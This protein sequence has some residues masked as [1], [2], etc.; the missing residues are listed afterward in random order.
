VLCVLFL[1]KYVHDSNHVIDWTV[2]HVELEGEFHI[3]PQCILDK[4]ETN[5][6]NQS[7]VQIKVQWKHFGLDEAT[8]KLE[9]AMRLVCTFFF[10]YN[11]IYIVF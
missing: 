1:K 10:L 6:Q 5:L 9:D 2:I 3:E 8:W 4:R 11:C 7:I